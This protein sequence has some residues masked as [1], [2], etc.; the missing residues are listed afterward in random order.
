MYTV[1]Q[2]CIFEFVFSHPIGSSDESNCDLTNRQKL[3]KR[4]GFNMATAMLR[5]QHVGFMTFCAKISRSRIS[6]VRPA[7]VN[8]LADR[9]LRLKGTL[10]AKIGAR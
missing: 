6:K 5:F 7:A 8:L 1:L 10:S 3:N 4:R 9:N 2:D